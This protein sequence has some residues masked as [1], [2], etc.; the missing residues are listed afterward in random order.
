MGAW[1]YFQCKGG[2]SVRKILI[3]FAVAS[4]LSFILLAFFIITPITYRP[5]TTAIN[6]AV[7]L[8]KI[9][10]TD[11]SPAFINGILGQIA[12]DENG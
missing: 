1:V 10:G 8:A 11:D 9:Y 2:G 5:S 6:E 12:R 4:A 3:L 7:E